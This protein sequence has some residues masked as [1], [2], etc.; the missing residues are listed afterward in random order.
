M[1]YHF[2]DWFLPVVYLIILVYIAVL[3][4]KKTNTVEDLFLARGSLGFIIIGFSL[5]AS[6]ISSTT[7]IGLAGSAYK[8]GIS[9]ANYEWMAGVVLL[10]AAFIF[11]PIYLRNKLNTVPEFFEHRFSI[12][13]RQY[14]Q[15]NNW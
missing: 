7:L 4:G 13:C 3:S 8:S 15:I 9:V 14:D 2:F 5:F 11:V 6:N 12:K 1:S 10:I